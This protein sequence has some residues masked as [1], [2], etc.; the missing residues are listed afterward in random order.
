MGQKKQKIFN[1][2]VMSEWFTG[3]VAVMSYL[4]NMVGIIL[5]M[6][7]FYPVKDDVVSRILVLPSI[8]ILGLIML[9]VE[10][11]LLS[12]IMQ[13]Y[14]LGAGAFCQK[15]WQKLRRKNKTEYRRKSCWDRKPI[16]RY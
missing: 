12:W 2:L 5:L 3:I 9:Y 6:F 7:A 15:L 16:Q 10:F 8:L 11:V 14:C 13:I 1:F 4:L